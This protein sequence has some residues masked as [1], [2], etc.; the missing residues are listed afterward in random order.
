MSTGRSKEDAKRRIAEIKGR[1]Q[2]I[3][4]V[5]AGTLVKRTKVCG[6][7]NC[8]CAT[9]ASKRH[10]PYYEWTK[11]HSG[12]FARR[13]LSDIAA[14]ILREAIKGRREVLR[15]LRQW[16]RETLKIIKAP[17]DKKS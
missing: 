3:E 8:Q 4:H 15:L 14:R 2:E 1:I 13:S 12:K 9:D 16:E 11:L 10:G 17:T 6:K 7:S 5:C